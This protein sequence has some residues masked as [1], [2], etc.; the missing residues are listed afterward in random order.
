[1]LGGCS[2][3]LC[4]RLL[5]KEVSSSAAEDHALVPMSHHRPGM[6][7]VQQE[8][9][10]KTI[11]W[12]V[13]VIVADCGVSWMCLFVG[14]ETGRWC[15]IETGWHEGAT[16]KFHALRISVVTAACGKLTV[17]SALVEIVSIPRKLSS[18]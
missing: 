18:V 10:Y 1:M 11:G 7:Q 15:G 8:Q 5:G 17:Q 3:N 6:W 4:V 12:I 16:G 9:L 2:R 13:N 14:E